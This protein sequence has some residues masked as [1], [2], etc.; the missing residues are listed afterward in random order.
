MGIRVGL[1]AYTIRD[2]R[3]DAFQKLEWAHAR[4]LEGVQF[5]NTT[6]LRRAAGPPE[7]VKC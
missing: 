7:Q 5:P 6:D 3:R 1:D 2:M 4:G